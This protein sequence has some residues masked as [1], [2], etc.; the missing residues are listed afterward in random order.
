MSERK[1]YGEEF[2]LQA[3]RPNQSEQPFE[4]GRTNRPKQEAPGREYPTQCS[5]EVSSRA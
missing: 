5:A 3:T 1:R 2:K 4:P